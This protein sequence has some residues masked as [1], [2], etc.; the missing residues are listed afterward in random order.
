M[1]SSTLLDIQKFINSALL[2]L[3]IGIINICYMS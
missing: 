3:D 2:M 1:T